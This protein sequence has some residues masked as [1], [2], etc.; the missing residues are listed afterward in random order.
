MHSTVVCGGFVTVFAAG[1]EALRRDAEDVLRGVQ[2]LF[3]VSVLGDDDDEH[4]EQHGG[5]KVTTTNNVSSFSHNATDSHAT[6]T[7][8]DNHKVDNS[9]TLKDESK[10]NI[11]SPNNNL[12][13]GSNNNTNEVVVG[14]VHEGDGGDHYDGD[15]VLKTSK[16][17]MSDIYLQGDVGGNVYG[18]TGD[19]IT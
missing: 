17:G 18:N 19:V 2:P 3:H 14:Q 13:L 11:I 10:H 8:Y 9:L 16:E 7:T 5:S 15:K 1:T 4:D 6:D 12:N